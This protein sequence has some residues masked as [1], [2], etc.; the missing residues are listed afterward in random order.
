MLSFE[1]DGESPA[2]VEGTVPFDDGGGERAELPLEGSSFAAAWAGGGDD[3]PPAAASAFGVDVDGWFF[4]NFKMEH[5]AYYEW[6]Y[7]DLYRD[8]ILPPLARGAPLEIQL[9]VSCADLEARQPDCTEGIVAPY[10]ADPLFKPIACG[11]GGG[12]DTAAARRLARAAIALALAAAGLW[13]C[14]RLLGA[15]RRA[16]KR[17]RYRKLGGE[18]GRG[19]GVQ[20]SPVSTAMAA[21]AAAATATPAASWA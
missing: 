12:A 14:G 5:P 13:A 9:N 15:A 21:A 17:G 10:P 6:S 18:V 11:D 8:G 19:G 3:T 7:L 2:F 20:L 1:A 16:T 4:W